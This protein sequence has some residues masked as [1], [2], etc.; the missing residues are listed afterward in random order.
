MEENLRRAILIA[1]GDALTFFTRPI[2]AGLLSVSILLLVLA[3]LP[4]IRQRREQVFVE[5]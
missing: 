2:S 1:R 4:M 3:V 5:D